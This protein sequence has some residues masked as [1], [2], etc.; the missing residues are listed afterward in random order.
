MRSEV[1]EGKREMLLCGHFLPEGLGRVGVG[2]PAGLL[3]RF[4]QKKVHRRG[5][6]HVPL[7]SSFAGFPF[8]NVHQLGVISSLFQIAVGSQVSVPT[9]WCVFQSEMGQLPWFEWW[10]PKR[11]I[12]LEC[13]KKGSL[14]V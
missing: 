6:G 10:S 3:T 7:V 9:V 13:L 4:L 1:R 12:S 11:D 14:Q 5:R 2:G 8:V